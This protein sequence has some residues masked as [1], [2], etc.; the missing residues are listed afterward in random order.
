MTYPSLFGSGRARARRP[1]RVS[2][3]DRRARAPALQ[4]RARGT[5][6]ASAAMGAGLQLHDS[7]RSRRSARADLLRTSRGGQGL[8]DLERLRCVHGRH[9][10]SALSEWS[11]SATLVLMARGGRAST[12]PTFADSG[13]GHAA[14]SR[15]ASRTRTSPGR[16][17]TRP[18][19]P[20]AGRG[21]PRIVLRSPHSVRR[22]PPGPRTARTAAIPTPRSG[23]LA[24]GSP[25]RR[26]RLGLD[27]STRP[28]T[29]TC[30]PSSG[31]WKTSA[32]YGFS[33][34]SVP[35]RDVRFVKKKRPRSSSPRSNT[36]R[37]EGRPAAVAVASVIAPES[38]V[39]SASRS[40]PRSATMGSGSRSW[41]STSQ[42]MHVLAVRRAA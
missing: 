40:Q 29:R 15:D 25:S 4:S 13:S 5:R 39:C 12:L 18:R 20:A 11:E 21:R 14:G 10:D 3:S 38:G 27:L 23:C 32:A 6:C 2:R 37:A 42:R 33:A 36:M 31:Q 16:S 24:A 1:R 8:S 26:R 28:S 7:L 41:R 9:S 30:R 22:A 35:L 17:C 34:T 19:S